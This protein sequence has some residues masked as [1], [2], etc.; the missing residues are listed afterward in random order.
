MDSI[1]CG[2]RSPGCRLAGV[3]GA[4]VAVYD[5]YLQYE[6]GIYHKGDVNCFFC[7]ASAFCRLLR[8]IF[9]FSRLNMARIPRR[10]SEHI[11]QRLFDDMNHIFKQFSQSYTHFIANIWCKWVGFCLQ[12][13]RTPT[14]RPNFIGMTPASAAATLVGEKCSD[15]PTPVR[16]VSIA[17]TYLFHISLLVYIEWLW[18]LRKFQFWTDSIVCRHRR[19]SEPISEQQKTREIIQMYTAN[20]FVNGHALNGWNPFHAAP[21]ARCFLW[22]PNRGER[23]KKNRLTRSGVTSIAQSS[24]VL[25]PSTSGEFFFLSPSELQHFN[26]HSRRVIWITKQT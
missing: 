20:G 19:A 2:T 5:E 11:Q 15:A 22:Q 8:S 17:T 18:Q 9:A 23:W 12:V 6:Q 14:P 24:A 1:D 3:A 16:L 25:L 7:F 4:F 10:H 13:R 21:L 26:I